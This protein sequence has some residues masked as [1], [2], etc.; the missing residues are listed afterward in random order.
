MIYRQRD[1]QDGCIHSDQPRKW[2]SSCFAWHEI[3]EFDK[4]KW[5][6]SAQLM[7]RSRDIFRKDFVQMKSKNLVHV[8]RLEYA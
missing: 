5:L 6:C 3:P 8:P 4:P 1:I 7:H 2:L